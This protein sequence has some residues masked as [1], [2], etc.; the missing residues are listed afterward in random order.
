MFYLKHWNLTEIYY[1]IFSCGNMIY[2]YLFGSPLCHSIFWTKNI[3][4]SRILN[5]VELEGKKNS[6]MQELRK[7]A[8][9]M[10][11]LNELL[12]NCL[13]SFKLLEQNT[14]IN[15]R[16]ILLVVLEAGRLRLETFLGHRL[17]VMSS[18]RKRLR[19]SE[20]PLL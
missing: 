1:C 19:S 3:F 16:N 9:Y 7:G 11:N 8:T 6:Q 17:L 18:W 14:I 15:S 2:F 12:G 4:D 20:G 5:S 13:G 10:L